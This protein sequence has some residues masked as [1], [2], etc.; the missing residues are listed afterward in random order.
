[1]LVNVLLYNH[2]KERNNSNQPK[3]MCKVR[4]INMAYKI[5]DACVTCGS[6]EPECPVAAI[7]P[8]DEK[9]HIDPDTCIECGACAAICPVEAI[10]QE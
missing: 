1:M 10:S 3:C 9:Y 2:G 7:T 5:S 4:R 8:G 6:C